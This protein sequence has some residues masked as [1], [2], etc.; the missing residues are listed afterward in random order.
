MIRHPLGLRL[1][2]HRP[3]RDQ[4]HEAARMGARGRGDRGDRRPGPAAAGRDG[5]PRASPRAAHGRALRSWPSAC[6]PGGAS[7]RPTSST[8]G[9]AAPMALSPSPTSWGRTWC[10]PA[11][12]RCRPRTTESGARLH[13]ALCPLGQRADHRGVRLALETGTEPGQRLKTLLDSLDIVGLAASIDPSS[14][15]RAGMDPVATS[16]ELGTWVAHAYAGDARDR[17]AAAAPIP[18]ASASRR[19]CSTGK[20]TSARSRRSATA[21]SSRSGR[22]PR[23]I[24]ASSSPRLF[25]GSSSSAKRCRRGAWGGWSMNPYFAPVD[26]LFD[27]MTTTEPLSARRLTRPRRSA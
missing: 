12:G 22:T 15:L 23:G 3:I 1:D 6:P 2:S 10:S 7:T 8:S 16:H 4:I 14:L 21:A 26:K 5:P 24:R 20:N 25:S 17:P 13:D 9:S 18:A 11:P 27:Y 19:G